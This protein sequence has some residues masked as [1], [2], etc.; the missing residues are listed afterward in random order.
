MRKILGLDLGTNSIG[1]AV[2]TEEQKDDRS[3]LSGIDGAG[4]RIIPMS[5]DQLGDFEKGNTISQTKER[6][7]YRGTRRL[8]E[9]FLLR[10]ERLHRTL[11]IMG[12]LP[13][14]YAESIDEFGKFHKGT[15]PKIEWRKG[16]NGK[17]EF[18]FQSSFYEML[19]NFQALHPELCDRKIPSDWTL[20][21][22]RKKALT[23]KISQEELAWILLNFNQKRGYYQLRGEEDAIDTSKKE[24]YMKLRIIDVTDS[25][26]KK[27]KAIWYNIKLENGLIYRRTSEQPLDWIGK[28][29]EFIITTKLEKDG[30]IKMD[31]DGL[32]QVSIRMPNDDDWNLLKKRT[33]ADIEGTH[34]TVGEYIYD[35][36]LSNPDVKI[37]GKLVRTI[38]RKYYREELKEIIRKQREFHPELTDRTLYEK[39]LNELYP[40]ND[41]YRN[42]I[43]GKDFIYLLTD[44]IIFYQRPLKSKK[45]LISNCPFE[46]R[47]YIDKESGELK[48]NPI[49]CIAKSHPLFQ[50]FR[51]WQFISNLRLYS[52]DG[53]N[54]DVT[55]QYLCTI[56]DWEKL[57]E[58]CNDKKD[59][60]QTTF[61]S[62]FLGLKKVGDKYPVRW[63][64]VEDKKYPCNKTRHAICSKLSKE[65]VGKL[66]GEL[67]SKIWH[68][69][70]SIKTKEEIDAVFSD[71]KIS[72][73]GIY[74]ELLEH[75]SKESLARIK[76][77]R[78]EEE[79]YGSY[80]EK[81][82]KKLLALMRIGKYWSPDLIDSE[83]SDRI[84]RILSG[85]FDPGIKDSIRQ[86]AS[87]L[88]CI[89]DFQGLP[90]WFACYIVYGRH[91]EGK[92]S[93]KWYSPKDID[94]FL[95]EFKQH[96]MRNP[97]VEQVVTE[98]LRT[99]RDIW[100]KTGRIDEIH[101]EL[102]RELK[103]TK[104][105]RERITRRNIENENTNQ[106]IR[107]LLTEFLNPEFEIE[108][109]RPY[110]PTQQDI[111]KIYEE[112]VLQDNITIE[113]DI[114]D[115]INK[116][117][118]SEP[119]KRPT[120][121]EIL[122]YKL[123][124]DQKYCSPY[125]G[126]PIPLAKLFTHEYE[127]EHI[128]PQSRYFDDSFQNKVI[129]EAEVNKL[130]DRLLGKEFINRH[131]G[132]IV[133]C[134]GGRTVTIQS[135][136][137]YEEFV[138]KH[139]S[140]NR[141]K[142]R[143]LLLEDIPD[144]FI[145]RQMNDTRYIS[146]YIMGLLSNIVR[147]EVAPGV[148][149]EESTSKN[150]IA[151]NGS[152]TTRLKKDWGLN[153]VWNNIILPRFIRLNEICK[154]DRFTCTNAEGHAIPDM[155][156]ELLKGFSK[157]RIDHRHHAMDAIVIAC[158]TRS[159]V[160]LLNNEAA[161]S[162]NKT[163]RHQLS[164]K[165]RRYE[166]I[167]INGE[168]RLVTKEFLK[169]WETF[170]Q[171]VHKILKEIIVSFK[172]NLRVINKASN[173]YMSYFDEEGNLRLDK[174]GHPIK[175]MTTQKA[176][177]SWWAIRKPLHKDTVFGKVRLR[178]IKEVRLSVA[179]TCVDMM[180][181]K[182][183]KK[184]IK[185]LLNR[186]Y[187]EKRIKK[188]FTEGENKEIWAEFNPNKI[189]VY[190]F[191]D[192]T[193]ATRKALD[194]S[195]DEKKIKTAVTDT[196]IQKILL[197]HLE[198]NDGNPKIAFSPD[199]IERMNANLVSL[200]GGKKHQPIYKIR[201]YEAASKFAVGTSGNKA[202]KF[203]EAA[204]GTNL[205]FGVYADENGTRSFVTIALNEVIERLKQGLSPVPET[206]ENN[207]K[208]L[209]W[210]SPNDLVYVPGEEEI[211][212]GI[213]SCN[214]EKI[215]KM[216]SCTGNELH[217]IPSFISSPVLQ[218][219]ELGSNNKAQRA[220]NGE[221]IKEICI[222]IKV[223]RLG[224]IIYIGTEF[225]PRD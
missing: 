46:T 12:F 207:A 203:V 138:K 208:L 45:H 159:H 99:V 151:C 18:I 79:D 55:D 106:R 10:R 164:H 174:S 141:A 121:S 92:E 169:P 202:D 17:Y 150:L 120:R 224:N 113:D 98:T 70:Y 96:S 11:G 178:K 36:I 29:K 54:A 163:I 74:D 192:D 104:E 158:A 51:L 66:S 81:A 110:S 105:Q 155:P 177:A 63:N 21:Y 75:F 78:L 26:E 147:E 47:T 204:K 153:D 217:C 201:V 69:L 188:F 35:N 128:I 53:T 2:V 132:E 171:D 166:K 4:S 196:G 148:F 87:G 27:G 143:N 175:G 222:P 117:N 34:K 213:I 89:N 140:G 210:L 194:D 40:N 161:K 146:R 185:R 103:S 134:S 8:R 59:L 184:E 83:T 108:G 94:I 195:F 122:K 183:L 49:K 93:R 102:G 3:Y 112:A 115:I 142:L 52:N 130:K 84:G 68:L 154:T 41:A 85:E 172:Q 72:N 170:T 214:V 191:T 152:I 61:I 42:S 5:A 90:V 14:H 1:W 165:L 6:T 88:T 145:E 56:K 124:L 33:E 127:I 179:L 43:Q 167:I 189:K 123:W 62:R 209:F 15:E 114:S 101:I 190:Y 200:N 220:W 221:M 129:C 186:G 133:T 193:F 135:V 199:G 144:G 13:K 125:T 160:H 7:G 136:E 48:T 9:R 60:D 20:Y 32:P 126:Q 95:A 118:S 182:E 31:K 50:E 77:V 64:Y 187:D 131:H 205:Y 24:E 211:K 157:N 25:G 38:E 57:F 176:N 111:L 44:D 100:I 206:N 58:F 197:N 139:Y 65:E 22:L 76:T 28:E 19:D 67:L 23:Q 223:D 216:V 156:D 180:V 86:R 109:V 162:S 198:E 225:L 119:A 116:L 107:T 168:E 39:C 91:S 82:I 71:S 137:G 97:I 212:T 173:K 219:T 73:G 218:T 37:I 215:Y 181:D 16:E 30:S 149:E 80:S